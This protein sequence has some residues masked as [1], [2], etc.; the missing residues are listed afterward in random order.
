M[1]FNCYVMFNVAVDGLELN[2][3][4]GLNRG[5]IRVVKLVIVQVRVFLKGNYTAFALCR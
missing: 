4:L 1:S 5:Q 3:R 2:Y